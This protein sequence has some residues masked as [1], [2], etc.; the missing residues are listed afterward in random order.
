MPTQDNDGIKLVDEHFENVKIY[1]MDTM[2]NYYMAEELDENRKLVKRE[3]KS[4]I[5]K[6]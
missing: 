1:V 2:P 5:V 6:D 3:I 4:L